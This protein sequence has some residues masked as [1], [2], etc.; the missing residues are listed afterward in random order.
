MNN[1]HTGLS[2]CPPHVLKSLMISVLL[3]LS[4]AV[5]TD[6]LMSAGD[7][8]YQAGKFDEAHTLYVKSIEA[9]PNN[10]S[11]W[12]N[13]A[14][15]TYMQNADKSG[16]LSCEPEQNFQFE[17]LYFLTRA[18]EID[19][20]KVQ[21]LLG[22]QEAGFDKFKQTGL[23]GKWR[24][25]LVSYSGKSLAGLLLKKDWMPYIN[26]F[27]A[28]EYKFAQD[29]KLYQVDMH[30]ETALGTWQVSEQSILVVHPGKPAVKY[31]RVNTKSYFFQGKMYFMQ[32]Q[33]KPDNPDMPLL[34]LGPR[35]GDCGE[36]NY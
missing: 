28:L 23:F 34:L 33:L 31:Q 12:Y 26:D 22:R 10:L 32:L 5:Y 17:V 36:Y 2:I 29:G 6:D 7:Q 3:L 16:E 27:P 1:T 8:K 18:A 9:N 24:E 13:L 30:G 14:R 20:K 4:F 11:G 19:G 15:T 35:H 21:S 25:T